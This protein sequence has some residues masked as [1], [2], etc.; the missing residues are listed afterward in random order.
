MAICRSLQ[1]YSNSDGKIGGNKNAFSDVTRSL[2][3][4]N[5]SDLNRELGVK[6]TRKNGLIQIKLNI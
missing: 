2:E 3:E 4:N 1:K 6:S 5:I